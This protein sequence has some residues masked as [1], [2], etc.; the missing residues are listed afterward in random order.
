MSIMPAGVFDARNQGFVRHIDGLIYWKRIHIR[1]KS[2]DRSRLCPLKKRD[3]PVMGDIRPYLVHAKRP[4]FLRDHAGGPF[5]AMG[6]LRVHMEVT[7][8][9]DNRGTESIRCAGDLG[10]LIRG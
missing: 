3:N 5:L 9:L 2:N 4:Q 8:D 10:G 7:T 1:P 6:K